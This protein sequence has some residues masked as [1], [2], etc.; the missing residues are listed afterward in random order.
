MDSVKNANAKGV[1]KRIEDVF[2]GPNVISLENRLVGINLNGAS[3]N[4]RRKR[5]V[6]TLFKELQPWLKVVH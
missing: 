6:A 3:V 1:K 2:Q 5:G 4:M